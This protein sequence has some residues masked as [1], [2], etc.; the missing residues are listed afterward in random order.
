ML[1]R[2]T[3]QIIL[4]DITRH[5]RENPVTRTSQHGFMKG[6]SCLTHLISPSDKVTHLVDEGKA[7][8]LMDLS[9]Q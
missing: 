3:E 1:G 4:S 5:I 9:L 7:V 8:D 2:V 6:R